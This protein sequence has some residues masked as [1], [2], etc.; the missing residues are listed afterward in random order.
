MNIEEIGAYL[1]FVLSLSANI[2]QFIKERRKQNLDSIGI[3]I[4]GAVKLNKQEMDT[5]RSLNADLVTQV[6]QQ[7][8]EIKEL[9]KKSDI[10]DEKISK[11][12]EEII[13]LKKLLESCRHDI[14]LITKT[15]VTGETVTDI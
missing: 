4:D 7:K 11:L 5:I 15:N 3:L 6:K 1:A 8:D 14:Q 13:T 10:K 12:E 2:F 9:E